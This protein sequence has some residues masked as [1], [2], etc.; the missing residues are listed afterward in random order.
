MR[1][2]EYAQQVLEAIKPISREYYADKL[3]YWLVKSSIGTERG[4]EMLIPKIFDEDVPENTNICKGRMVGGKRCTRCAKENGYCG[5]HK[6]QYRPAVRKKV[7]G[8]KI[9]RPTNATALL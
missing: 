6:T 4:A 3:K 9:Q 8:N 1:E 7:N 2:E 5:Y